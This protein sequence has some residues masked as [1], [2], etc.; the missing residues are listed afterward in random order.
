MD[1]MMPV[2]QYCSKNKRPLVVIAEAIEG[3]PLMTLGLNAS[4]QRNTLKCVAIKAPGFGDRRSEMLADLAVFTGATLRNGAIGES[5]LEGIEI[6]ELG[7]AERVVV[8]KESTAIIGPS[9]S[10]EAIE[11]RLAQIQATIDACES[12]HESEMHIKR[13]A[14]LAG[15]VAVIRVGAAT[16]TEMKERRDRFDDALSATRAAVQEGIVCG[17]G[18]ALVRAVKALEKFSTG[19]HE[20]DVGVGI[21]LRACC[22]P[23]RYI[24]ENAGKTGEVIVS[25]VRDRT[26][27]AVGF[28]ARTLEFE[29]MYAAGVI[30]PVKVTRVALQ[31]AASIAGLM[32]TTECTIAI[33]P[34]KDAP[35]H[36]MMGM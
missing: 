14:R 24:A 26:S 2:L 13:K 3:E 20:E 4:P 15:G 11:S 7:T 10:E 27:G 8:T 19:N 16:E 29:D 30:D 23:L 28:N 33:E 22:A 21:V 32:L 34:K 36:N 5:L 31:N 9:G 35:S 17:G 1:H 6:E 12:T 18:T 25:E